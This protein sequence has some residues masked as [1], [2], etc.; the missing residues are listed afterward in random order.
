MS[1]IYYLVSKN[2]SNI[3]VEALYVCND[4]ESIDRPI[5]QTGVYPL[6]TLLSK[7]MKHLTPWAEQQFNLLLHDKLLFDFAIQDSSFSN[8]VASDSNVCTILERLFAYDKKQI[9]FLRS[10]MDYIGMCQETRELFSSKNLGLF[11]V[12]HNETQPRRTLYAPVEEPK[13]FVPKIKKSPLL[14]LPANQANNTPWGDLVT[15]INIFVVNDMVDLLLSSLLCISEESLYIGKCRY[16]GNLFVNWRKVGYCPLQLLETKNA[17]IKTISCQER[18]KR[19]L[20]QARE[21]TIESKKV[22]KRIRTMLN[23]RMNT[24]GI[25]DDEYAIRSKDY[26]VFKLECIKLW[27]MVLNSE[28]SE[29]DFI[30]WMKQYWENKKA[31]SK[32]RKRALKA[33]PSR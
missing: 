22:R 16:C 33:T 9:A 18:E 2:S 6:G 11:L 5:L 1:I 25:S 32:T 15:P 23:S 7:S 26:D 20:Q 27:R 13:K 17:N 8:V 19:K 29:V 21:E 14:S 28:L 24:S 4:G 30:T 10:C 3:A 31:E 12:K